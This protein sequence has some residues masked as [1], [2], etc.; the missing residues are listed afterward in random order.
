MVELR[1]KKILTIL[2][3]FLKGNI[4]KKTKM[5]PK[6]LRQKHQHLQ[7]R[8]HRPTLRVLRLSTTLVSIVTITSNC[9]LNSPIARLS[10]KMKAQQGKIQIKR[11]LEKLEK[12]T[13][14]L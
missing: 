5:F 4:I 3:N 13:Q 11:K 8:R 2:S 12:P 10:Q 7:Y 14:L 6:H 9:Y 1:N